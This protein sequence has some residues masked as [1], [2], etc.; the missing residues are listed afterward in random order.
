M[1]TV[2]YI[3]PDG[4][5]LVTEAL[6]VISKPN[7]NVKSKQPIEVIVIEPNGHSESYNS[8]SVFVMNE[9]GSTV[10]SWMILNEES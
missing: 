8:G 3:S 9:A 7:Q 10:S 1:L 4:E 6:R 5:Q 2:K